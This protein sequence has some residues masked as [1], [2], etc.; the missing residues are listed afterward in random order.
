MRV[1]ESWLASSIIAY[2]EFY[3]VPWTSILK[4]IWEIQS[5]FFC[6]TPT[7]QNKSFLAAL[8]YER[9]TLVLHWAWFLA[10]AWFTPSWTSFFG[11]ILLSEFVGGTSVSHHSQVRSRHPLSSALIGAG[12]ALIVF[13]NHYALD[14]HEQKDRLA[15]NFLELQLGGTRNIRPTPFMNWLSVLSS[16]NMCFLVSTART[17]I[18]SLDRVA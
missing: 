5:T 11:F 13:M 14:H 17:L 12:I 2:Q 4:I 8:P 6:V 9:A 3:F 15:R 10:V 16:I 1:H 18:I 7:I